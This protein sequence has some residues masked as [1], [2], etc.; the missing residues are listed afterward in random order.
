MTPPVAVDAR[1]DVRQ[2]P[3]PGA[4][5]RSDVAG[6]VP[7]DVAIKADAGLKADALSNDGARTDAK[8][9]STKPDM[10]AGTDSGAGFD[11]T[12]A[13]ASE[14][15][16]FEADASDGIGAVLAATGDL[17]IDELLINPAGTDTNREWIEI[18]N[19]SSVTLDLHQLHVDDAASDVA[20]DAGLLAPGGLLVLGQSLDPTKNGGA[21]IAFSFGN[22]IS[23]NN[24]GDSVSLCLGPC[25]S[26]VLLDQVIWTGDL[27]A[28]YDGHA[29]IVGPVAGLFCPA[30]QPYGDAGSFG[31]PGAVNPPCAP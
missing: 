25:T 17:V 9:D 6:D 31:S 15:G 21:P 29:A 5:A 8:P 7:H 27:G 4:D 30:D 10:N 12:E 23:L 2:P 22:V 11:S 16:P 24:G 19:V 14:T 26:G 1:P 20:V 28:A 3:E 18:A 13:G